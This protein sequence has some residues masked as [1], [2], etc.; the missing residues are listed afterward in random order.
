[1]M[2]I[3]SLCLLSLILITV[4]AKGFDMS[5]PD[6]IDNVDLIKQ[7]NYSG[8]QEK[9]VQQTQAYLIKTL[10]LEPI[11]NN[12]SIKLITD[13]EEK[14][15]LMMP[16]DNAVYDQLMIQTMANHLAKQDI[17]KFKKNFLNR[18]MSR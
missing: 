6:I 17:L 12:D 11:M 10:F 8:K 13:D 15:E 14:D 4:Q 7:P 16:V 3:L 5:M 1:M 2:K 9:A 18:G